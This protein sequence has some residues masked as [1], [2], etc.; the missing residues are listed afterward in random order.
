LSILFSEARVSRALSELKTVGR[1]N[2]DS[3]AYREE[4]RFSGKLITHDLVN[5]DG[6]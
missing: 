5:R 1:T 4:A 2:P 3:G 6:V